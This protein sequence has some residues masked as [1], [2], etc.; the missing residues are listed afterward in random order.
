MLEVYEAYGDYHTMM[1][2]TESLIRE[3]AMHVQ[4]GRRDASGHPASDDSL[5][6]H[7][8]LPFGELQIDYALPFAKVRYGELFQT[9]LG[10]ATDDVE[11]VRSAIVERRL[12]RRIKGAALAPAAHDA[13]EL[14]AQEQL[15]RIAPVLLV[16]TLFEELAEP[17]LDPS[18]PTFIT[19]YPAA[20]SPLTRPNRADPLLADRADLFIAHMELAPMY[21][22][23]NDPDVQEAK[24]RE[25]LA[26]GDE[27]ERAFRTFDDD[28]IRALKVG[29][30]PAG[31]M[32]LGIDRLAMLLTNQRTIRD[33]MLF[34]MM[35]PEGQ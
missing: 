18:R 13:T 27:E 6:D 8:V 31:G 25:Q 9:V 24:F 2:L 12:L 20:I 19:E 21:T 29:M 33:V 15:A 14:Q 11:R 17:A 3:L 4:I 10:F 5:P 32:G 35:R 34:P 7:I 16:N 1:E 22:E 30:P 23:L 26:G 28:F